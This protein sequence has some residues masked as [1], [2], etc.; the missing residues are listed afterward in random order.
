MDLLT[1]KTGAESLIIQIQ[2][3]YKLIHIKQLSAVDNI[4]FKPELCFVKLLERCNVRVATSIKMSK[5]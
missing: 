1:D 3:F 2:A 5:Y 4:T